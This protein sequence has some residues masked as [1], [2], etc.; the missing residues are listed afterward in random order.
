M[1]KKKVLIF[2][3]YWPP[4]GGAGVQRWLKFTK[5]LHDFNFEPIIITVDEKNSSYT[6]IDES[7]NLEIKENQRVY[8]TNSFEPLN[9]FDAIFFLLNQ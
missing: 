4:A 9:I 3:Y 8:K 7:L 2:T 6:Q 5:Y 1:P